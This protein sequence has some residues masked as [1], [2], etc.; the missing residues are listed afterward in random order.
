MRWLFVIGVALEIAGALLVAGS[1]LTPIA[2]RQWATIANRGSLFPRGGPTI[3]DMREP[4]HAVVGAMLLI[5]GFASQ[6]AGYVDEF[7]FGRGL[8]FVA[9]FVAVGALLVGVLLAHFKVPRLLLEKAVTH[10]PVNAPKES[11]P[12]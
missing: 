6:L 2:L 7:G 3:D 4:A 12:A 11:N 9:V 1:L 10:D 5:S 8:I